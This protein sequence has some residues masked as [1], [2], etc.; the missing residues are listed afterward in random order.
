MIVTETS[1]LYDL[2]DKNPDSEECQR[3][4][5][6]IIQ[7]SNYAVKSAWWKQVYNVDGPKAIHAAFPNIKIISWFNI[8]KVETEAANNTV[9]WTISEDQAVKSGFK[10]HISSP[11]W[12]DGANIKFWL[13]GEDFKKYVWS[14]ALSKNGRKL[15]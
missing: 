14:P 15:I 2:C 12:V 5:E 6:G 9:D 10:Q 7:P 1:A 11:A 8:A 13:D 3:N 4:A